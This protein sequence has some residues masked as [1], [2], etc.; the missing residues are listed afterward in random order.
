MLL[1]GQSLWYSSSDF[2]CLNVLLLGPLLHIWAVTS[3]F[4]SG[5]TYQSQVSVSTWARLHLCSPALCDCCL[6]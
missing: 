1:A 2:F 3:A 5:R 4:F 6:D